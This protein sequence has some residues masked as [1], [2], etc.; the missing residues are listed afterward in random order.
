MKEFI[1]GGREK[2][3]RGTGLEEFLIHL[4]LGIANRLNR[5]QSAGPAR[6][7]RQPLS[8]RGGWTDEKNPG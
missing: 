3:E 4:C 8:S 6:V 1:G 2:N 5:I 7:S